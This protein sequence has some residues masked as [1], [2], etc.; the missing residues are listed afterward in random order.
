[1]KSFMNCTDQIK[2][3]DMGDTCSTNEKEVHIG[4]CW[5]NLR[6][7]NDLEDLGMDGRIILIS[8]SIK[9]VWD[10]EWIDLA[11]D[12]DSWNAVVKA[13]MY[14]SVPQIAGK[15]LSS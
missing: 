6:E 5:G 9:C 15:L 10:M 13:A 14:L 12:R 8:N 1:M 3:N 7:R 2:K 4:F 11:K